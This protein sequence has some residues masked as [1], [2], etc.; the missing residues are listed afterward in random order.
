MSNDTVTAP[1]DLDAPVDLLDGI[2]DETVVVEVM[3]AH[4]TAI[5][6]VDTNEFSANQS[7]VATASVE[8]DAYLNTSAVGM[9]TTDSATVRQSLAGAISSETDV[10]VTQSAVPLIIAKKVDLDSSASCMVVATEAT[11]AR[12]WVG[13]LAARNATLSEDSR[14]IIDWKAAL[15]LG[16]CLLGGFGIIAVG[17]FF[18]ARR[19]AGAISDLGDRIP[20]LP[21]LSGLANLPHMPH[22][23]HLSQIPSWAMK[24]IRRAA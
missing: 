14:V 22:M 4:M 12:S 3:E 9:M 19:I 5:A 24:A 10:M 6:A 11:A 7:A 18:G 8:G 20:K 15:I 16:A 17:V 23:P 2:D 1:N 13:L 21:D